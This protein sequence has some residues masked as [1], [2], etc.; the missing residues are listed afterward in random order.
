MN[1]KQKERERTARNRRK[2]LSK[3]I[4]P[5]CWRGKTNGTSLCEICRL[6]HKNKQ[7]E[8]FKNGIC[9]RCFSNPIYRKRSCKTCI[10][11]QLLSNKRI[12]DAAY[13]AYGG[14]I[15]SCCKEKELSFLSIDHIEND[16][17]LLRKTQGTGTALYRW[18][19]RNNFPKGYQI[20]CMNCQFGKSKYGICPHK[21]IG[22]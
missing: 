5:K 4:C 2:L 10:D 11:K 16:G 17:K 6:H 19:V 3:R 22:V 7:D 13:N 1:D 15:C 9:V 14:Y 18:L 8:A 12:K 20:L 21:S